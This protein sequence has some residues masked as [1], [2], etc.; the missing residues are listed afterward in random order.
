MTL[1][2]VPDPSTLPLTLYTVMLYIPPGVRSVTVCSVIT[3]QIRY[4]SANVL[5]DI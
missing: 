4:S 3:P 1:V 2:N 5:F